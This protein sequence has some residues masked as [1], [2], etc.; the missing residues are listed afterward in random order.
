[1]PIPSAKEI[2]DVIADAQEIIENEGSRFFGLSY[3]QG[4][5]AALKWVS[6]EDDSHPL[7]V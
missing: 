5:E 6:G 1:M 4:V 3:E 2:E 7:E